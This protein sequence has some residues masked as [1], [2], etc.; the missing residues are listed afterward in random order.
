MA[1]GEEG[2]REE[3]EEGREGSMKFL[4]LIAGFVA[5]TCAAHAQTIGEF[6][7]LRAAP[8]YFSGFIQG[9]LYT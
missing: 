3:G 5:W 7:A 4:A 1:G 9:G 8:A 6:V 2:R